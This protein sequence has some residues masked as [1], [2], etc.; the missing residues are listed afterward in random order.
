MTM[1]HTQ[2]LL[3]MSQHRFL[4]AEARRRGVSLSEVDPGIVSDRIG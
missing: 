4:L 1:Q 3:E 2:V